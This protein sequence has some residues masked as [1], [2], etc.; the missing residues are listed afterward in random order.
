MLFRSVDIPT[1]PMITVKVSDLKPINTVEESSTYPPAELTKTTS[2]NKDELARVEGLLAHANANNLYSVMSSYENRIKRLKLLVYAEKK[3]GKELPKLPYSAD[4]S[5]Y[6][7]KEFGYT[8]PVQYTQLGGL[9]NAKD[10]ADFIVSSQ[11]EGSTGAE[12][13]DENYARFRNQTA[14]RDGPDQLHQAVKSIKKKINELNQLL[15]YTHKLR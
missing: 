8:G 11:E 6:L 10:I 3:L 1:R 13:L 5:E 9:K 7:K 4:F 2:T 14:K 15:E 12:P